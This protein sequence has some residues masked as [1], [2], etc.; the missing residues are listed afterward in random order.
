MGGEREY[1]RDDKGQ[2]ASG[3]GGVGRAAGRTPNMVNRGDGVMVN[4]HAPLRETTTG[5]SPVPKGAPT[6]S[7]QVSASTKMGKDLDRSRG[8]AGEQRMRS[9]AKAAG[10][11]NVNAY[12]H[13][14]AAAQDIATKAYYTKL[15][16][17][18]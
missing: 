9:A 14:Q 11:Q 12:L 10:Y 13:G 16:A 6:H 18:K 8:S 4:N 5:G 3:G 2:F 15:R 17:V 7:D 1:D